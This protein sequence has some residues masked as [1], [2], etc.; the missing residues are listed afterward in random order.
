MSHS[1]TLTKFFP[2]DNPPCRVRPHKSSPQEVEVEAQGRFGSPKSE[3]PDPR[4][5][6]LSLPLAACI[7]SHTSYLCTMASLAS[8][9]QLVPFIGSC[10]AAQL[11]LMLSE[12]MGSSKMT[13]QTTFFGLILIMSMLTLV[14]TEVRICAFSLVVF[15]TFYGRA[16]RVHESCFPSGGSRHKCT[17]PH[18]LCKF[19]LTLIAPPFAPATAIRWTW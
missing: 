13:F 6:T 2:L 3:D 4:I 12:G 18:Q 10:A 1:F 8:I 5:L 17:S 14:Q 9:S 7:Q 15:I 11:I 16:R 19:L